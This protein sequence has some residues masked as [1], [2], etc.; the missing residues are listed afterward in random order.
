MKNQ[1]LIKDILE[2]G[3]ED[4]IDKKVLKEKLESGQKLRIK[5][6]VDP[7]GNK[8]HLGR[9]SQFW[10]LKAFQD[11]GHQIV[12]IIG[13]FTALIGDASDKE[14]MRKPLTKEDIKKNM[15][16]YLEQI[17]K[18][19]DIEKTEIR[20]NSEWFDEINLEKIISIAMSFT[21]QQLIG[22]RNFKER[23]DSD[24][25]IGLHEMLYPILQGYDSVMIKADVEIGGFD[26]LF[27]LMSGRK[28]QKMFN[29]EPQQIMTSKMLYGLDGRKMS[30]SWG[31]VVNI[32]DE[33]E[34]MYGKI[35]SLDDG[36]LVDYFNFC[37]FYSEEELKRVKDDLKHKNPKETKKE[38]ARAIVT[39]YYNQKEAE[40]AENK[41]ESLFE[42]KEIPDNI[43]E[44]EIKK[45]ELIALELCFESGLV[46]NK[47]EAKR[48]IEQNGFKID[49]KKINDWKE[50][51]KVKKGM[52]IQ[53]GKRKFVR[54]A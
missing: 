54:V 5:L 51:I 49:G 42:A 31:N 46:E 29:Q 50:A 30:T 25:P 22:R 19:I 26:Q 45:E 14:S 13:D 44:L 36:L 10:K 6:G 16:G 9:A 37:A 52:V 15:E 21:A 2:R 23:W 1:E 11:L 4:I 28:I 41:F 18:I 38:L 32:T 8:I 43:P 39:L 17:G 35:M 53:V 20:Y 40:I 33:P 27:N 12:F 48:V 47:S 24:K 3:T 7:T 34:N